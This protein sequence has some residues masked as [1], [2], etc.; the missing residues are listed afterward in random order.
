MSGRSKRRHGDSP[1]VDVADVFADD[2]LIDGLLSERSEPV[3]V[4]AGFGGRD[5]GS[6]APGAMVQVLAAAPPIQRCSSAGA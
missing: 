5:A 6:G 1:V 4:G 3:S 2:A